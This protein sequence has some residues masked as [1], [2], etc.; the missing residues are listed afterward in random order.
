MEAPSGKVPRD[1]S[2]QG[3]VLEFVENNS[4]VKQF[5]AFHQAFVDAT[6]A[7]PGTI[8]GTGIDYSNDKRVRDPHM[9]SHDFFQTT[10]KLVEIGIMHPDQVIALP[11]LGTDRDKKPVIM[12]TASLGKAPAP[13]G[14]MIATEVRDGAIFMKAMADFVLQDPDHKKRF[15][16]GLD[17]VKAFYYFQLSAI[18]KMP[19]VDEVIQSIGDIEA[20]YQVLANMET[21]GTDSLTRSIY[22]KLFDKPETKV[23]IAKMKIDVGSA[24]ELRTWVETGGLSTPAAT[25]IAE[26]MKSHISREA[27]DQMLKLKKSLLEF[28]HGL[29]ERRL[30]RDAQPAGNAAAADVKE[31]IGGIG[32]VVS[33]RLMRTV[34]MA[35]VITHLGE[36]PAVEEAPVSQVPMSEAPR[37]L[38]SPPPAFENTNAGYTAIVPSR[39]VSIGN[40]VSEKPRHEVTPVEAEILATVRAGFQYFEK[41]EGRTSVK[42]GFAHKFEFC[43]FLF[44]KDFEI[45]PLVWE[46]LSEYKLAELFDSNTPAG[47]NGLLNFFRTMKWV[48]EEIGTISKKGMPND[49]Y[50]R[51]QCSEIITSLFR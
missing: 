28:V 44:N 13:K 27:V 42:V 15:S 6:Q 51:E 21:S 36:E 31:N 17:T 22:Q 16:L 1:S 41:S 40:G 4:P 14:H 12:A 3:A 23:L 8:R 5:E 46:N 34:G 20:V 49:D 7:S 30:G 25:T 9:D 10:I 50:V 18:H 33:Q 11:Y 29:N 2:L 24:D 45:G 39:I 43:D 37:T 47:F 32:G 48:R 26:R 38:V 35:P 19:N